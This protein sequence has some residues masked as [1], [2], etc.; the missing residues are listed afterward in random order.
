MDLALGSVPKRLL[1]CSVLP[2]RLLC[3]CLLPRTSA[4]LAR[5]IPVGSFLIFQLLW[6]PTSVISLALGWGIQGSPRSVLCQMLQVNLV[7]PFPCKPALWRLVSSTAL[8]L[9]T[10]QCLCTCCSSAGKSSSSAFPSDDCFPFK[11][12]FRC[13]FLC[14]KPL[15]E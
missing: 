9:G 8:L 6:L 2:H 15:R 7:P 3:H 5:P 12:Q 10:L 1:N 13:H 4:L 14:V 11:I